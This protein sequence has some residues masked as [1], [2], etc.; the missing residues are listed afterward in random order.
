MV[1]TESESSIGRDF[2]VPA[3]L[4]TK[5]RNENFP[6]A[7]RLL[8][9]RGWGQPD[10]HLRLRPP[11]RRRGRRGRGRS[12]GA[13]RLA[14]GGA[15]SGSLGQ[16]H[17]PGARAAHA[18]DP[19]VRLEPGP[20][21]SPHRSQPDGPAHN[22][23]SQLRRP[24][25]LLHVLRCAGRPARAGGVRRL[26]IRADRVVGQGLHRLAARRAPSR[27]RRGL[28]DGA[29]STC[30]PK[31]WSASGAPKP[32]CS[33]RARPRH[34]GGS[35]PWR[36]CG[37][38]TCLRWECSSPGRS[39]F[40]PWGGGRG[41]RRRRDV[42]TRL[43]RTVGL[44][45][46]RESLPSSQAP[47]RQ[48]GPYH[49]GGGEQ[50]ARRV[51]NTELA[52]DFCEAVTRG[53]EELRIW[54]Q[55]LEKARTP[56]AVGGLCARVWHRRHRRRADGEP[57]GEARFTPGG[58]QD[59]RPGRSGIERSR[60]RGRGPRGV[61][62]YGLSMSCFGEIIDGCEMDVDRHHVRDDRRSRRLLPKGGGR[63]GPALASHV[64]DTRPR[65]GD[66]PCGFARRR[67]FSSRTSCATSSRT[68]RTGVCTCRAGTQSRSAALPSSRASATDVVLPCRV[69]A[70]M[71]AQT[72]GSQRGC[73]SCRCW[74][75]GA[76][77]ASPPWP[78]STGVCS[79]G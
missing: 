39:G 47:V 51:V 1:S 29:G 34:Y 52:Y 73:S 62:R 75:A 10:G 57:R 25:G 21:S 60:A 54:H 68:A 44:R 74:T 32:N 72:S 59:H 2:D 11:D 16:G 69:R 42:C 24:R 64:R 63:G 56:G 26:D 50:E 41:L 27:R 7:S 46:A 13:P 17:T 15:R 12:P 77:P 53:G 37:Q 4:A 31:T 6:V 19:L 3:Q 58:P 76:E 70:R 14:R 36:C 61:S 38:G 65:Q 55:A 43:D 33:G 48:A 79:S 78:A 8:P 22:T 20:V 66:P 40:V 45:R 23:L 5:A 30:P 28:R 35:S 71:C 49:V 9:R 67:R 18:G